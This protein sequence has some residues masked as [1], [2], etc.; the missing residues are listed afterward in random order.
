MAA[1]IL[2]RAESR[3]SL[4]G[5][6]VEVLLLACFFFLVAGGPPP[7]V[8]E[9]HYLTKAKH[10]WD[11][12][13][14]PLDFF[15]NS[16]DAHLAFYW[17]IGW[18]TK[19]CSL[20]VT[21]WI[22]R[23]IVWLLVAGGLTS[24]SRS[25]G[26]RRGLGIIC[27]VLFYVLQSNFHLAG[28]WVVGG[29]E[30]K[31]FAYGFCLLAMAHVIRNKWNVVWVLLGVSVAFHVLV[32]GWLTVL[33]VIYRIIQLSRSRSFKPYELWAGGIGLCIGLIGFI[34][35]W[36]LGAAADDLVLRRA[37][38]ISVHVRLSHHLLFSNFGFDR[39]IKFVSLTAILLLVWWRTGANVS[40]NINVLIHISLMSLGL[41][42][43]GI[44]LDLCLA[45]ASSLKNGLL[46]FYWFRTSDV[47]VPVAAACGA[48]SLG[49]TLSRRSELAAKVL[50]VS[51]AIIVVWPVWEFQNSRFW[52]PRPQGD[53]LALPHSTIA[54]PYRQREMTLRI[55]RHFLACCHWIR[56]HTPSDAV[57]ITPVRQQTFKWNALRAEVVTR[58]DMPQDAA[59][60]VGW[61]ERRESLYPVRNGR[62]GLR[63]LSN[64]E[65]ASSANTFG[66]N[67]LLISQFSE[68]G[69]KRFSD[70]DR[71][72]KEFPSDNEHSFYAVYEVKRD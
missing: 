20:T 10:Y 68:D 16:A 50:T 1:C 72:S 17:S 35:A 53:V 48:V 7:A 5:F 51:I 65:I 43:V 41:C 69:K 21:A 36:G 42:V 27:G 55:E 22:A 38:Y 8:N 54:D 3:E 44:L 57:V 11:S 23:W 15:L 9:A 62:R 58:K 4:T 28:E 26:H 12:G 66:A 13:F 45:D 14:A 63:Q 67:Y 71:F 34:P 40:R 18:L 60:L 32:G 2:P 70:D 33:I 47:L 29:V 30:G 64:D 59:G 25:L 24:L 46:R 56:R 61:Y 19:F 37:N 49:T 31:G 6:Y 52:D 39:C